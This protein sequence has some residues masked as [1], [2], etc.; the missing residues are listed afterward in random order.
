VKPNSI[1]NIGSAEDEIPLDI[2]ESEIRQRISE[3]MPDFAAMRKK[4]KVFNDKPIDEVVEEDDDVEY[5]RRL[6]QQ[7]KNKSRHI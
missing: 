5:I 7:L 3:A 1:P 6:K 4:S 2:T